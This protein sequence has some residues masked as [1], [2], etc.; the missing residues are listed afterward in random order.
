MDQLNKHN[1]GNQTLDVSQN[2]ELANTPHE[3]QRNT[4]TQLEGDVRDLK[5]HTINPVSAQNNEIFSFKNSG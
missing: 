3:K 2:N 5:H 4:H 1:F